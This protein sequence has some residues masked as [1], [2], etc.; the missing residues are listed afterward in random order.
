MA[1]DWEPP[2]EG[3]PDEGEGRPEDTLGLDW[4]LAQPGDMFQPVPGDLPGEV[5]E[6][7]VQDVVDDFRAMRKQHA[8]APFGTPKC[9]ACGVSIAECGPHDEDDERTLLRH[10]KED[11][12]LCDPD[13]CPEA[14]E[15]PDD[16]GV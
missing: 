6:V 12:S 8:T 3:P 15:E 11:H 9:P 4:A 10:G 14:E 13:G 16:D 2:E 1:F 7:T 5:H